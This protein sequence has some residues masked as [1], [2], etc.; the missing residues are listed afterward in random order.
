LPGVS[1]GFL[2]R[3]P[4]CDARVRP[5]H[6]RG[7][8]MEVRDLDALAL[9]TAEA[10]ELLLDVRGEVAGERRE[11]DLV[12]RAEEALLARE[13]ARAVHGDDGL[14]G[15]GA[16][17]DARGALAAHLHDAPLRGME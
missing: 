9:G 12:I 14:A 15:T 13:E 11:Q 5:H 8:R 7:E 17:E 3:D 4:R 6:P 1:E 2:V 16:A 10:V